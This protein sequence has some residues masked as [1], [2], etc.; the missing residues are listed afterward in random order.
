MPA[1]G[2]AQLSSDQ[3]AALAAYIYSISHPA[4]GNSPK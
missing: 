3:V 2:G 1:M 4:P